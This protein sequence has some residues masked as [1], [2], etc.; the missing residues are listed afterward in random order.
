MMTKGNLMPQLST[1]KA[2]IRT[3]CKQLAKSRILLV[4]PPPPLLL[5]LPS[6]LSRHCRTQAVGRW[7]PL[8]RSPHNPTRYLMD[9]CFLFWSSL[10]HTSPL[11]SHDSW[12]NLLA[13]CCCLFVAVVWTYLLYSHANRKCQWGSKGTAPG[14]LCIPKKESLFAPINTGDCCVARQALLRTGSP[15]VT[16]GLLRKKIYRFSSVV[17]EEG[18]RFDFSHSKASRS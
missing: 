4:F 12:R 3:V 11:T 18:I 13:S 6:L 2:I 17:N 9:L 15:V 8:V 5:P 1:A 10:Q 16:R 7:N 14:V